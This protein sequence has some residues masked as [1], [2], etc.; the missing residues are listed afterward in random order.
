[1]RKLFFFWRKVKW[2]MLTLF[3]PEALLAK[4]LTDLHS[5]RLHSST[6][7]E[8]ADEDR[9][10]WSKTHT[11]L[12]DMGGF[13]LRFTPISHSIE[14]QY[15][16]VPSVHLDAES[17]PS[18]KGDF[19]GTTTDGQPG[20]NATGEEQGQIRD[21]ELRCSL[22]NQL[23]PRY[24]RSEE[25]FASIEAYDSLQNRWGLVG[26]SSPHIDQSSLLSIPEQ[27]N[28]QAATPSEPP[29]QQ[30]QPETPEKAVVQTLP[31]SVNWID[32]RR[33]FRTRVETA[34][35]RFGDIA[36]RISRHNEIS[37]TNISS[38]LLDSL[39]EKSLHLTLLN[40][41]G[42]V[43]VL[44]AAQL[45]EARRR[46]L[47]A[48]LPHITEDEI[49]D[50]NK[51]DLLLKLLALL[52]VLWMV[53]QVIARAT[54]HLSSTPLE[55]MTLSFAAC[56]FITYIL[57]L[58]HPQDVTT[59][60]YI[61]A[62]RLSTADDIGTIANLGPTSFWF[63]RNRLPCVPNNA[64]HRYTWDGS[65]TSHVLFM[66]CL[67]LGAAVFGGVHTVAWNFDFP[68]VFERALW[69][70]SSLVTMLGPLAT[71]LVTGLSNVFI[72]R[73]QG[74]HYNYE[75]DR[76][77]QAF[78]A[79]SML[80]LVLAR[81]FVTAEAFRSLYYLPQDAYFATWAANAPFIA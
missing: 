20:E 11:L 19:S 56:A 13:A 75:R 5:C 64:I 6:L 57:L 76:W 39:Y 48:R 36:W 23:G 78:T 31:K 40:F 22:T 70:A 33:R 66:F 16:S 9:V 49:S 63:A 29:Q 15:P 30:L 46:K 77:L 10:P 17:R 41:E 60:I 37:V 28:R 2:M 68:T 62:S 34:S 61:D 53:I 79:L 44:T 50:R 26:K 4:A 67:G 59:S 14:C 27:Y 42:D 80:A 32:A 47:I 73:F 18:R 21:H 69:R 45:I 55:I 52:Q 24:T 8:L 43:W 12:A 38:E 65:E 1:M 58:D 3:A 25:D 35:Q 81:L 7:R 74:R 54:L 71:I 72:W 51:G